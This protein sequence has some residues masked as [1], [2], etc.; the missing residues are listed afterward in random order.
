[1]L[2]YT[3]TLPLL[4][5]FFIFVAVFFGLYFLLWRYVL[6]PLFDRV[7]ARIFKK[8]YKMDTWSEEQ[9]QMFYDMNPTMTKYFDH[10]HRSHQFRP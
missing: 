5:V 3:V 9:W 2:G 4:W 8:I 10:P 7:L 1:V 6:S